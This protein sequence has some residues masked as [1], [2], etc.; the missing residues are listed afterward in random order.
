MQGIHH[1]IILCNNTI[2]K[3]RFSVNRDEDDEDEGI[4]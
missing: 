1:I 2:H 3:N 4:V